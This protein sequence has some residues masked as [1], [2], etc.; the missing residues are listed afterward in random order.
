[1]GGNENQEICKIIIEKSKNIYN[2][3]KNVKL[4][5]PPPPP[6]PHTQ[7]LK[8]SREKVYFLICRENYNEVGEFLSAPLFFPLP[9]NYARN[10]SSLCIV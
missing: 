4:P 6:P 3:A 9:Y 1:M 5:P 7:Y 2:V 8:F 10:V